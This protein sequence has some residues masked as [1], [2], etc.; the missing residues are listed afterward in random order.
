MLKSRGFTT[1]TSVDT[2]HPRTRLPSLTVVCLLPIRYTA[3]HIT[4]PV[5]A[6]QVRNIP[7]LSHAALLAKARR[8]P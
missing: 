7:T 4:T 8:R 5:F 2:R 1:G 6:L 3:P